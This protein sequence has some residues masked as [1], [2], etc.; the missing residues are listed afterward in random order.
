MT[1]NEIPG[2]AKAGRAAT[3]IRE[4]GSALNYSEAHLAARWHLG[5]FAPDLAG[6]AHCPA[7]EGTVHGLTSGIHAALNWE[8]APA[9]RLR[10][11]YAGRVFSTSPD[12]DY[13]PLCR[14]CHSRHDS[15]RKA[16][17][18]GIRAA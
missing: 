9:E 5:F 6:C 16:L 14:S 10:I 18:V 2:T 11:D 4:R 15:W 1:G 3:R 7:T 8:Q 17:P 12:L 13:I